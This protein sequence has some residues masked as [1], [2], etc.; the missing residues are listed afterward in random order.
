MPTYDLRPATY[1][2]PYISLSAKEI[3]DHAS[4]PLD[5]LSAAEKEFV[6]RYDPSGGWPFTVINGQYAQLGQGYSPG[7]LQGQT[8]EAVRGQLDRGERNPATEAIL[9]EGQVITRLLCAST[10]DAP[11]VACKT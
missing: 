6:N 1:D 10:G 4:K 7:L 3:Y 5:Q 11:S 9:K 2:S 8:F